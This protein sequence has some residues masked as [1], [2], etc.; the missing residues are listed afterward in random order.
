MNI[1]GT[2][3]LSRASNFSKQRRE[4]VLIIKFFWAHV[5]YTICHSFCTSAS[6]ISCFNRFYSPIKYDEIYRKF[7]NNNHTLISCSIYK[8]KQFV[9]S[10]FWLSIKSSLKFI[11]FER[12]IFRSQIKDWKELFLG[13]INSLELFA[14]TNFMMFKIERIINHRR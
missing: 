3:T 7:M 6:R 12:R 9:F 8:I 1:S 2:V 13:S 5:L 4:Y 14:R 11:L 10:N